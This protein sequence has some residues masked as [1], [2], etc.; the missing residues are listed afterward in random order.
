[1]SRIDNLTV[2][3]ND[4]ASELVRNTT[5]TVTE[6]SATVKGL[7]GLDVPALINTAM[8]GA[9]AGGRNAPTDGGVG[10]G[11]RSAAATAGAGDVP[12]GRT[13]GASTRRTAAR[14][15]AK[16]VADGPSPVDGAAQ[17]QEA[18]DE[19][20]S[21]MRR[22]ADVMQEAAA[23]SQAPA[24]AAQTPVAGALPP[25]P[26]LAAPPQASPISAA[27]PLAE[28]ATI[29]ADQMRLIPG[30]ERYRDVRLA[31]L[32]QRGSRPVRAVWRLGRERLGSRYGQLTV[33]EL[34]ERF[35]GRG[36]GPH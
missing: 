28:A 35:T 9:T 26:P 15:S 22:A 31:D 3:S 10:G 21:A 14:S 17:V 24:A 8:A 32:D 27:T 30:I 23:A 12:A 13:V 20:E 29:L 34:L 7:T 1:M 33:G 6:A 25:V 11:G 2:L 5:R 18:A 16:K 4:G 36:S 19:A